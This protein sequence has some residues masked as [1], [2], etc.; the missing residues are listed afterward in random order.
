LGIRNT[1]V[2]GT[3]P[4]GRQQLG[5]ITGDDEPYPEGVGNF[6]GGRNVRELQEGIREACN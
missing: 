4:N 2:F 6:V 5:P 3:L 1:N